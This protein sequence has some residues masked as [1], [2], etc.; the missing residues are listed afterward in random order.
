VQKD[1]TEMIKLTK[2]EKRLR[3]VVINSAF[4]TTPLAYAND[5]TILGTIESNHH[6]LERAERRA[7]RLNADYVRAGGIPTC[8]VKDMTRHSVGAK[9]SAA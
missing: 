5:G 3:Y 4:Q 9:D 1:K 6:S 2:D 7:E 8:V